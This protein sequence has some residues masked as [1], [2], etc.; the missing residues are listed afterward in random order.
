M[1]TKAQQAKQQATQVNPIDLAVRD[2]IG[3][4]VDRNSRLRVKTVFKQVFGEGEGKKVQAAIAL[5]MPYMNAEL[6]KVAMQA[7]QDP[8]N[9]QHAGGFNENYQVACATVLQIDRA[10]LQAWAKDNMDKIQEGVAK[11]K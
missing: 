8:H 5:Y 7:A 2:L 4:L 10:K 1:P 3:Y 9:L 11:V 6:L